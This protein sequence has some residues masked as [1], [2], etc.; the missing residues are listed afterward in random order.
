MSQCQSLNRLFNSI[1]DGTM[2]VRRKY[3]DLDG[4]QYWQYIKAMCN[5]YDI[6]AKNGWQLSH[7]CTVEETSEVTHFIAQHF[8]IPRESPPT[9]TKIMQIALN[10]GQFM[11]AN[12]TELIKTHSYYENGLNRLETY[13]S[14]NDIRDLSRQIPVEMIEDIETYIAIILTK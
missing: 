7:F 13:I 9:L 2:E 3:P 8:R 12:D 6:V 4:I 1:R 10:S 14:D 11:A 5:K